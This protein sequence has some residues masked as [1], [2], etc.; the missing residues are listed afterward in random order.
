MPRSEALQKLVQEG[1]N[2]QE[3][4]HE[5][6]NR[7]WL[8]KS[9]GDLNDAD[10]VNTAQ[11]RQLPFTSAPQRISHNW[12]QDSRQGL[13]HL[14]RIRT[15]L[16]HISAEKVFAAEVSEALYSFGLSGF[17]AHEDIEP[18]SLWEATLQQSIGEME[19]LVALLHEGYHASNWTDQEVGAAVGRGLQ[20][21]P[22]TFPNGQVPYGFIG[23]FQTLKAGRMCA[24]QLAKQLLFWQLEV[25]RR[26]SLIMPT[27]ASNC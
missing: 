4:K 5:K 2:V 13:W 26:H 21:I 25:V 9:L 8:G 10:L 6:S 16:S 22:V 1:S 24:R 12:K 11:A 7:A 23:K 3:H 14:G 20:V 17:V 18:G 27:F 19:L 15:F